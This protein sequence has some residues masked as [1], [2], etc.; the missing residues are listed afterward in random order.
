ASTPA[1]G[2]VAAGVTAIPCITVVPCTAAGFTP[3]GSFTVH[4]V[5]TRTFTGTDFSNS[6]DEV[7]TLTSI[8]CT[9][10]A[11]PNPID[12]RTAAHNTTLNVTVT[13]GPAT[14]Y[15][16]SWSFVGGVGTLVGPTTQSPVYTA[17][18]GDQ[19]QTITFTVTATKKTDANCSTTCSVDVPVNVIAPCAVNCT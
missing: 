7:V 1:S 12:I 17:A 14:D 10:S 6:C 8:S 3:N 16:Y 19:G 11:T 15:N 9:A 4:L 13:P 2:S 18:P 5:V